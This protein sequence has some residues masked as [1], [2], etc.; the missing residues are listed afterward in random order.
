L[1]VLWCSRRAS[2]K[3]PTRGRPSSVLLP[4]V[5]SD[6]RPMA[7]QARQVQAQGAEGRRRAARGAQKE[8]K[9]NHRRKRRRPPTRRVTAGM[10]T[11]TGRL[12]TTRMRS[13]PRKGR[14]PRPRSLLLRT[15]ATTT[16]SAGSAPEAS[17]CVPIRMSVTSWRVGA[18]CGVHGPRIEP[19]TVCWQTFSILE[20]DDACPRHTPS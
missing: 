16:S 10:A 18:R 15:P 7:R 17:S 5:A 12:A 4:G 6:T 14:C 3:R 1:A 9:E 13:R 19:I 20:F 8:E 11:A 2:D